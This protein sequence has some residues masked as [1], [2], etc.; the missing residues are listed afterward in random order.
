[1]LQ[2][3]SDASSAFGGLPVKNIPQLSR[4]I[5]YLIITFRQPVQQIRQMWMLYRPGRHNESS[6]HKGG[7]SMAPDGYKLLDNN[8]DLS[9]N[10]VYSSHRS[11]K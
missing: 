4:N 1:M 5:S 11:S 2:D 7:S 3:H 6:T 9:Y 8:K 10:Q